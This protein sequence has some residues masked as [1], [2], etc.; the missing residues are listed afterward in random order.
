MFLSAFFYK[1][2]VKFLFNMLQVVLTPLAE[3]LG[4][5]LIG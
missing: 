3:L 1:C 4:N 2:A 5:A